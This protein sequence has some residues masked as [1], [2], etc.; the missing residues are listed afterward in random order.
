MSKKNEFVLVDDGSTLD[1][2]QIKKYNPRE[3]LIS[4]KHL[5]PNNQETL[6]AFS[7]IQER[8]WLAI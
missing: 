8:V 3:K 5:K 2:N 1:Y 4:Q 7:K 6:P